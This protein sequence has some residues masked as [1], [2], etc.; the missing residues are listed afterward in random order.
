VK[1]SDVLNHL[2]TVLRMDRQAQ[3]LTHAITQLAEVGIGNTV[4]A[5]LH[6][7]RDQVE[8]KRD[9]SRRALVELG[10]D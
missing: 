7:E 6:A 2:N 9:S 4:L 10:K 1:R 8:A 5:E 3:A